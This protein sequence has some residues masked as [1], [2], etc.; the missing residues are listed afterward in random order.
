MVKDKEY[1]I[2]S[3]VIFTA[4]PDYCKMAKDDSGKIATVVKVMSS[5]IEIFIPDSENN[6]PDRN[7]TWIVRKDDIR[8]LILPGSQLL[9]EFWYEQ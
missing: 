4:K 6:I 7:H 8:P 5:W 9:F 2:G 3:K 1:L